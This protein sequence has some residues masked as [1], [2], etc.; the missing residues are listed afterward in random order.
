M[1]N[2]PPKSR[3]S[4]AGPRPASLDHRYVK[5]LAEEIFGEDLHQKRIGSLSNGIVGVLHAASLSIHAIGAAYAAVMR[6]SSKHGVKQIDRWLSND[7][8]DIWKLASS[9][10]GFVVGVREEIVVALDWTDFDKDD[11]T[12]ICAYLVTRHGRATPL[13]WKTAPKSKL[14]GHR[15]DYER[16][17]ITRLHA[18]VSPRTKVVL[19]ADRG[20]GDQNYTHISGRLAGSSSS[21]FVDVS[22]SRMGMAKANLQPI[23]SVAAG[24]R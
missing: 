9:W 18:V 2:A 15:N 10:I 19:L 4:S 6:G 14:E 11:H 21:G 8:F 13:L 1:S 7:A 16:E 12:T 20:F 5:N 22:S 24:R 3:L 17:V 23:G